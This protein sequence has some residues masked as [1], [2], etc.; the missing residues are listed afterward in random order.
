MGMRLNGLQ[1][2]K[3]SGGNLVRNTVFAVLL[4]ACFVSVAV[5]A[6]ADKKATSVA[7]PDV[8]SPGSIVVHRFVD[9]AAIQAAGTKIFVSDAANNVVNIYNPSGK[10]L[11]QLTGFS[12]PQG[13]ATDA[14]GNLYVADTNNSQILVF[15]PPY[16]KAPKK[17]AD[18]GYFPAG[19]NVVTIG[20]TTYVGVTNICSAPNCT[21]GGFIV[22]KNGKSKGAFQSSSIYRVY[23][24]GFDAKGNLYAD[25]TDS[26]GVVT[27]GEVAKAT[28]GGTTFATLTT[29]NTISFPGGVEVTTKGKIAIDDQLA[30][31]VFT[32][33]PPKNGSL[34]NPIKTTSLTGSGDAVTFAFT[35]NNKDL[36]T[37]DAANADSAEFAYPAGGSALKTIPVSGGLPIGAAVVPAELP[38][39]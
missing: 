2:V 9:V 30:A 26:N 4:V 27:V 24:C 3:L 38:G 10:Q 20:T 15:K 14:K 36:W 39:K 16:N 31:S 5:A 12:Q 19:V 34:G 23:F 18:P 13:L 22:Y 11:A 25:G 21:Q 7:R 28:R 6:D 35:S 29:G 33:N 32:Y 8:V 1:P 17:L 37:A